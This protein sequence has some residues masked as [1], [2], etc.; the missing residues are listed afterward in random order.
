[1]QTDDD[2]GQDGGNAPDDAD[3]ITAESPQAIDAE[4]LRTR[5][6]RRCKTPNSTSRNAP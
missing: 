3:A 1:M 4:T 6:R 5:A 2:L